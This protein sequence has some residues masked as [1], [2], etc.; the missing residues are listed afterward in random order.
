M[1]Y[2]DKAT[3]EEH[4]YLALFSQHQ[5]EILAY[6]QQHGGD[7]EGAFAKVTGVPWP[8][9]RSVKMS[10]GAPEI[11]A[12]R[13]VK[14]VLGRYVAPIAAGALG[15]FG[16]AGMGPLGG[17]LGG[18][19]A[20]A[21]MGAGSTVVPASV[22]TGGGVP[23]IGAGFGVAGAAKGASLADKTLGATRSTADIARDI[24]SAGGVAAAGGAEVAAGNRG[25]RNDFNMDE[26]RNR[27]AAEQGYAGAVL[28]RQTQAEAQQRRAYTDALHAAYTKTATGKS[29]GFSPYSRDIAAPTD[30]QRAVAGT[31]SD[32]ARARLADMY[33]GL[34]EPQRVPG[35]VWQEPSAA[36]RAMGITAG[37]AGVASAVPVEWWKRLGRWIS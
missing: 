29:P 36:E 23:S 4:A 21:D 28:A 19:G 6:K 1:S 26:E 32:A 3:T 7:L 22:G 12:D 18:G 8:E 10:N 14:S 34:P 25:S 5:A 24:I 33:Q 35:A 17:V 15:G 27:I 20:A 13:T 2:Q 16:L 31:M 37:A 11:T 30:E 9:N